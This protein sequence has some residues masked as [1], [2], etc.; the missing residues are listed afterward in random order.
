M[1][2][3][4]QRVAA[5]LGIKALRTAVYHP[6][7]N[8]PVEAFHRVLQ[9][10]LKQLLV[11]SGKTIA[12]QDALQLVL[13]GY[14]LTTHSTTNES[15]G[16]L[17]YGTDLRPAQENDW[18]YSQSRDEQARIK[19]LN[20]MRID[21]QFQ[22]MRNIEIR[23]RNSN[24]NRTPVEFSLNEL[25]LTRNTPQEMTQ[26]SAHHGGRKLIPRWSAPSRVVQVWP[27][28]QRAVVRNLITLTT[29]EVH[30]QDARP[31][32]F[33]EG[34]AQRQEWE[35]ILR[36]G[37]L[38]LYDKQTQ[39]DIIKKFWTEIDFPQ[40]TNSEIS[41]KRARADVEGSEGGS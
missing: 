19:Y 23:N 27:G 18:R 7:G 3:M 39:E 13:M 38:A 11:T 12:F 9:R 4:F 30:L 31:L 26:L 41:R 16:F 20:D 17:T 35:K 25:I 37:E 28:N 29:K 5:Q 6:E 10:G 22:A 8:A 21:I 36:E 40:A 14:R 1:G 34:D 33:P 24:K 32:G 15:P 2:G